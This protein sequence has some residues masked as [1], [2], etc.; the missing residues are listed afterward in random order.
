MQKLTTPPSRRAFDLRF[1]GVGTLA[2]SVELAH[3]NLFV[4]TSSALTLHF[5]AAAGTPLQLGGN[6]LCSAAECDWFVDA[7]ALPGNVVPVGAAYAGNILANL[8]YALDTNAVTDTVIT[9]MDIRAT[10]GVYGIS[11]AFTPQAGGYHL[12]E[13]V[14]SATD[15]PAAIATEGARKRVVTA[16]SF[17]SGQVRYLSYA[18]DHDTTTSGYDT[19]VVEAAQRDVPSAAQ[20]LGANGFVVTAVGGNEADGFILVGTRVHGDTRARNVLVDPAFDSIASG[21]AII[22]DLVDDSNR[23]TFVY[24]R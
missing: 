23:V 14:V 1:K 24:Q 7:F 13:R 2:D 20:A 11:E 17:D 16:L 5:S 10:A 21:Y 18:W 3:S 22:A 15:L 8:A 9:S 19:Q 6:T 4:G 12:V